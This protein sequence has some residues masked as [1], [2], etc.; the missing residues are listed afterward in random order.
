MEMHTTTDKKLLLKQLLAAKANKAEDTVYDLSYG[1]R[2]LW[3][4]NQNAPDNA[5]YNVAIAARVLSPLD[6]EAW[7]KAC[8]RLINRHPVLRTTYSLKGSEL[9]QKV[10]GFSDL[11]FS[12]DDLSNLNDSDFDNHIKQ[13]YSK[14][15]DLEKGPVCRMHLF[16]KGENDMVFMFN[17]H[18]IAN[19]GVSTWVLLEDLKKLYSA[20]IANQKANLPPLKN[21]YI[22]FVKHQRAY[23]EGEKG[24]AALVYWKKQLG[25][26]PEPIDLPFDKARPAT[27][28]YNGAAEKLSIPNALTE[29]LR[30]LAKREGVTLFVLLA[31][32]FQAFLHRYSTQDRIVI[33]TPTSG[34]N[35]NEFMPIVGYF[36]NPVPLIADFDS[37]PDFLTF[38]KQNRDAIL[39]AMAQQEFPFPYL[40]EK[41]NIPRDKSRSP[42]FQVFFS[43]LKS[44]GDES[45][46]ALMS[47]SGAEGVHQWGDLKLEAYSLEQQ[48]GQFDLTLALTESKGEISGALKYNTDL[49]EAETIKRLADHFV[50]LL[51]NIV[52]NPQHQISAL[53]LLS[54]PEK[55]WLIHDLNQT[56]MPYPEDK[57]MHQLFE[58]RVDK[59][60]D[61]I[62][63]SMPSNKAKGQKDQY[64]YRELD[65][66]ANQVAHFLQKAGV[67]PE[68]KVGIC[69]NRSPE[70]IIGILGILK[71]GGAYV[72][73]DPAYPSE[74]LKFI[75]EDAGLA[76]ILTQEEAAGNLDV[77]GIDLLFLDKDAEKLDKESTSRP[78]S[79]V[80][81][82]NLAYIIYTSGSTGKPKGVLIEHKGVAN[83]LVN[84]KQDVKF[85][86]E[87]RFT[88]LASYA[89]DASIGQMF[90]PLVNG[91]PL[92]LIPKEDQNE[93][94]LYWDFM[95]ENQIN[96]I[97][98]VASFLMPMLE[99][100]RDL[101]QMTVKYIFLGAEVFPL[102]LLHKI[103]EKLNAERIINMYGPT[104][105]TVNCVMY[106]VEGIP[107]GSIPLGKPLPN[108]TFYLLDKHRNI[109]PPGVPGE[110]HIGGPAVAR[111]Y[112]NRPE[113][114]AKHF[115]P[116]PFSNRQGARLYR[117]GDV[118][119]Y[120]PDGNIAF[121]G[122]IDKQIKV[123]GFR[124]EPGEIEAA[125]I[126]HN[127]IK[128]ALVIAR[129]DNAGN[130]RLVA[131][132]IAADCQMPETK[133]LRDFLAGKLP[134]Y[135]I[136]SAFVAMDKFP[137]H[138][139]GKVN[140]DALPDPGI[141]PDMKTDFVAPQSEA[142]KHMAV[143]W[144]KVLGIPKIGVHD[145]FFELGGASVQSIQVVNKANEI[146]FR[147]N[148][149]MLFELPTIAELAK[150]AEADFE[151][152]EPVDATP[153]PAVEAVP[154]KGLRPSMGTDKASVLVESIGVYL[155]PKAVPT[156]EIL[157]NCK[158]PVRF[159]LEKMTGIETRRMA[160]D[161][162]FAIDLAL[163]AA[164]DAL[165]KSKYNPDE[166]ELLICCNIS[167]YDAPTQVSFEPSTAFKIR[168][169]FG[170]NNA[171]VFDLSNACATMW[172]GVN[173]VDAFIQNGSIK[174][175]MVVSGEYI[176]HITKTA[177]EEIED[178]FMDPRMACLTV[179][180]SGA[181][182]I[183]EK[184]PDPSIGLQFLHMF[185]ETQ[186][187]RNCIAHMS[188]KDNGGA[189]MYVDSVKAAASA[190][191]PGAKLALNMLE[192]TNWLTGRL[193]H[194]LMHQTSTTTIN[195]S[196]REINSQY[197]KEL[198]TQEQ[199]I[200]NI[201]HRGNTATTSH[202]LAIA[203]QIRLNKIK[204]GQKM[205][206]GISGSGHTLGTGL[207]TFDDL[208]K[209]YLENGT[210]VR[211][212]NI[213]RTS[214]PRSTVWKSSG[215][216]KIS[217]DSIGLLPE[218][219]PT[220][221]SSIE[222]VKQAAADCINRSSYNKNEI[223]LVINT[224][225]Y[226][227]KFLSEPA[228]AALMAGDLG[229]N[230]H[231]D[232]ESLNKSFTFDL[233]NGALGFL[234]ACFTAIQ[235]IS[236]GKFQTALIATSEIE[237]NRQS[238][239]KN[240]L[241]IRE[242]GSAMLL[243][244]D[245]SDKQKGFGNFMFQHFP[246]YL[247]TFSTHATWNNGKAYLDFIKNPNMEAFYL[248]CV[249]E[250]IQQFMEQEGMKLSDFDLVIPPQISSGFVDNFISRSG[251]P[252]EK[253]VN[254]VKDDKD[255]FTSSLPYTIRFA[256]EQGLAEKGT[257]ALLIAVGSGIQ[258]GCAV[259]DF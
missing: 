21:T 243:H 58:D 27:Q 131:Y 110:I 232:P 98:T 66:R 195:D 233:L 150:A 102:K 117:S 90:M 167:R 250:T 213:T 239:L 118:A 78:A 41:L 193:D 197:K 120:L 145:N 60:P 154:E 46:Q 86:P 80:K 257:K 220:L 12:F 153:E 258:V 92:F 85:T 36:V 20:E 196:R 19:D 111:G 42:V 248:K 109:V 242:T 50:N 241:D 155:P 45:V 147:I 191:Q 212:S 207:Y 221:L 180:D 137:L 170:M 157:D 234:E 130:K 1:Q 169:H 151:Y 44:Q 96:V 5:A 249:E 198:V 182:V 2:S 40:V 226:R 187:C 84:F 139:S 216:E 186:L 209:R 3:F 38:L 51:K 93:P 112:H 223:G 47:D 177:M 141:R 106:N 76:I 199:M 14:P 87:H 122:R 162:E 201:A 152:K 48:Q 116:D 240:L 238:G 206:F 165:S 135:M 178:T 160:G 190:I 89:F 246:A 43:F 34:R 136:P 114:T 88:L 255:L 172:T 119:K 214:S 123:N 55:Q 81:S 30:N 95:I 52:A 126:K 218:S 156:Q 256:Q 16:K 25:G 83:K 103:K 8:Q 62:A 74:R 173:I 140:L 219:D 228:V 132:L 37:N 54:E 65:Q 184:S 28:T 253:V 222:F 7:K 13:V 113:Q 79:D 31:S 189:I 69:V 235:M 39:E 105:T 227:D 59:T 9:K 247:E 121:L 158:N 164:E 230:L 225:V 134:S 205:V 181:A 161:E 68:V 192:K 127:S 185:T 176:T 231:P 179:G 82:T 77:Q 23:L 217:I 17:I 146:G 171:L 29:E 183:L 99:T 35:R 100:P 115:I 215:E 129:E 143:I 4:L 125:I 236:A 107:K 33:G 32:A 124:I 159:P 97:Y 133:Q 18:H 61:N 11:D 204:P 188:D 168:K 71:A 210:S 57:C 101:R 138:P 53:E 94:E 144:S 142:E 49:F 128:D 237:N 254:I 149:G 6:V 91:S 200:D 174:C 251:L 194:F 72:P 245:A 26:N 202:W 175:G 75:A 63:V 15:F 244:K 67:G 10:H 70:M 259:Y 224:G 22:D 163:K 148:A 104:E 56:A 211:K 252:V 24:K 108:Y 64:T 229:I 73:L 203:D 166:I 208:P